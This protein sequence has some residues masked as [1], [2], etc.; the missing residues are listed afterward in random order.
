MRSV[1][2]IFLGGLT[3]FFFSVPGPA[4]AQ[5]GATLCFQP[6]QDPME[7]LEGCRQALRIDPAN[8]DAHHN[9]GRALVELRAYGEALAAFR[10]AVS[11]NPD[12]ASAHDGMGV[13]L[14]RLGRHDEA[15]AAYRKAIQLKPDLSAAKKNLK[16]LVA[17]IGEKRPARRTKPQAAPDADRELREAQARLAAAEE[18]L[19]R[20]R[21][22]AERKP[23][24]K[25][26]LAKLEAERKNREEQARREA[27]R[28]RKEKARLAK[29]ETE[30]K[31]REEQA[32]GEAERKQREEQ[33]RLETERKR[34]EKARLA[35]LEAEKDR[36]KRGGGPMRFAFRRGRVNRHAVA[37]IIGNRGYSAR[38]KDVPDVKYAQNDAD[39]IYAY[40][41]QALGY[42]EGNIIRLR[43]ATQAQLVSAFGTKEDYKGKLHNWMRPGKSDVFV[44]YSGH[45]VPGLSDG[46]GYLLPV[47]A[48]P[49]TATLNGY[50]L[51]TL[52]ANLAKLP[53]RSLTVMIDACFSG[54][55]AGGA[56]VRSASPVRIRSTNP[57]RLL[58]KAIV[59]TASAPEEV[60]SWDD[61]ARLGLFT[62][63]ILEG[64]SGAADKD[65]FGNGD[66]TVTLAEL[67]KF[68]KEEV[69]YQARRRYGRAQNPQV[70]GNP[71]R[72]LSKL[73]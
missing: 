42:R 37:V 43:D 3:A 5:W 1:T 51:D 72:V 29:L 21:L 52:Y 18:N 63:H 70:T 49:A 2:R 14:E 9:R 27:E 65:D 60:A 10:E 54:G 41:T 23:R 24:E 58:P 33:A 36:R 7:L 62:R 31:D 53:A 67:G 11:L 61:K 39:A 15:L 28:K 25:E 12:Y 50:S 46:K 48:D 13:T 16:R 22:E 71:A 44:F 30:R 6:S 32:R 34:K 8:E 19:K 64:L 26:R 20:A 57:V 45:G 35:K 66:G 56:I 38:F 47:D 40:V 69:T 68:L 55:S 59:L 17:K 4:L 73:R